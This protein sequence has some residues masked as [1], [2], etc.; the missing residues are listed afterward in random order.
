MFRCSSSSVSLTRHAKLSLSLWS[1]VS[2]CTISNSEAWSKL[3]GLAEINS[4]MPCFCAL[5]ASAQPVTQATRREGGSG[6]RK[7]KL[8]KQSTQRPVF[9]QNKSCTL[10]IYSTANQRLSAFTLSTC[11]R[12]QGEFNQTQR[13]GTRQCSIVSSTHIQTGWAC[14]DRFGCSLSKL[15]VGFRLQIPL[16]KTQGN[17]DS[18]G[19][20]NDEL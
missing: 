20:L 12:S 5:S 19:I 4:S 18:G 9:F 7:R 3:H 16:I 15:S 13:C 1:S 10:F 6:V 8:A 11:S 2:L 17:V 14:M